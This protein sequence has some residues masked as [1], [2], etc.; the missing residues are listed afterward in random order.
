MYFDEGQQE[1]LLLRSLR[2]K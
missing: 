1:V 2:C